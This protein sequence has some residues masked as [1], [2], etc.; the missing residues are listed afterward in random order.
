[1]EDNEMK[2]YRSAVENYAKNGVDY[3]FHNKGDKHAL[4]I[5]SNLLQNAQHKIR[6]AANRLFNDEVVNTSEYIESLKQFLDRKDTTL[7]ILVSQ[8]PT[9][10]DFKTVSREKTLYWMLFNHPAY[11][12][13]R[14]Q[15]KDGGGKSFRDK[16]GQNV[17]FC[18]GDDR[19]FRLEDNIE[20]RKAIAN[21]KDE[22]FTKVLNGV[23][24]LVYPKIQE[25]VDLQALFSE[26]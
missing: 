14:I 21:F 16:D 13:G 8:R 3:L 9:P 22:S 2:Q 19:M 5:L 26:C 17:N 10:E 15:I 6:I 4:I 18:T 25:S 20:Q 11:R 1:M 23:F 12:Q 24:D 7:S